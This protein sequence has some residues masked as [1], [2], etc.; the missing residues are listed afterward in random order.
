MRSPSHN[1]SFTECSLPVDSNG[2]YTVYI[3]YK[4]GKTKK[5]KSTPVKIPE[6]SWDKNNN[7]IRSS[8]EKDLD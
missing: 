3:L 4:F 7:W 2:E 6:K 5:V 8:H 1:F